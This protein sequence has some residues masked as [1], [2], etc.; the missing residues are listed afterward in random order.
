MGCPRAV[1]QG[2]LLVFSVCTHDPDTGILT[3]A[4][5]APTYRVYR[6]VETNAIRTGTMTKLDDANTA[7]FYVGAFPATS[8]NDFAPGQCYT[9]Y[10]EATVDADT[11]GICY[12]FV[13]RSPDV[14][15]SGGGRTLDWVQLNAAVE[16][17]RPREWA[18]LTRAG[19]KLFV[20]DQPYAVYAYGVGYW[21]VHRDNVVAPDDC[22]QGT[23]TLLNW[24][25]DEYPAYVVD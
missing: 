23:Q 9:I 16:T 5:T 24:L 15:S 18:Y 2:S 14:V 25:H 20:S 1:K 7:G 13:V 6:G 10:I 19:K 22:L 4:D 3:D 21:A 8:G 12:G 17:S 11:G